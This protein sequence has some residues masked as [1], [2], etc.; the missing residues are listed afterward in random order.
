[1]HHFGSSYHT[2]SSLK[3]VL[4]MFALCVVFYLYYSSIP[5]E[6]AK[7]KVQF[8]AKTRKIKAA[9]DCSMHTCFDF[10][11]CQDFKVGGAALL[12]VMKPYQSTSLIEVKPSFE[13]LALIRPLKLRS[14]S[15]LESD[16]TLSKIN[17]IRSVYLH[18]D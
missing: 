3:C 2:I 9:H 15:Y 8:P 13:L 12:V 11:R 18:F 4:L 17:V 5:A 6:L 1:M 10:S 7:Q 16:R 14:Y